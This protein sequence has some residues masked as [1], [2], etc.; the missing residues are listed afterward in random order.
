MA[1]HPISTVPEL[2]PED[3]RLATIVE[4]VRVF[5]VD[6]IE[7]HHIT[8]DQ[9]HAAI[10]FLSELGAR[11][12]FHALSD[13]TRLSVPVDRVTNADQEQYTPSNVEGPFFLPDAPELASPARL[14]DEDKPG[15]HVELRGRVRTADG[16]GLGGSIIDI[17]QSDAEGVYDMEL[18]RSMELEIDEMEL[19]ARVR[20]DDD[21]SFVI[22][23]I[24]PKAYTVPTDGALGAFLRKIGRHPWRPAHFHL[25]IEA[26]GRPP[27][28]TMLYLRDDPWLSVDVI[29]SI[30]EP[31]LVDVSSGVVDYD[32]VLAG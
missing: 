27:L 28:T 32:F 6:L 25:R 19:R 15:H 24:A 20:T 9:W 13:I 16:T 8:T 29:D 12:E 14:C 18:H 21:G 22:H 3:P 4:E 2:D 17:W 5:F 10:D 1:T 26:P 30:K 7:R 31:L 11:K 23:T